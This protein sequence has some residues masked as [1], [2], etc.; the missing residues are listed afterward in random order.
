M[1]CAPFLKDGFRWR[2]GHSLMPAGTTW[3]TRNMVIFEGLST[4]FRYTHWLCAFGWNLV[5]CLI[6]SR[7]RFGGTSIRM[8]AHFGFWG[9]QELVFLSEE[10]MGIGWL[11][12]SSTVV[13]L[14]V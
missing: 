4:S 12:S 9:R 11:V 5:G 13:K 10:K 7:S 1:K 2:V 14:I 6:F 3:K 8:A